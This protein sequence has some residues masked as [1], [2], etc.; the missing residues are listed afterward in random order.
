LA[1][2]VLVV[3]N[4]PDKPL[5]GIAGPLIDAGV[6][7]DVRS[8]DRDLPSVVGYAG[9]I[10]LPGLADPVD[11]DH[12]VR[13][14]RVAIDDALRSGLPILGLCLGGQLLV[15]ALGGSVYRCRPEL[16]F[17]DVFA[18]PAASSD[19][20]LR[21]APRRFSV[22]HAHAY[23]FEPPATA[24]ILLTNDVCVQACR[25]GETWAFQ[26]HPEVSGEWAMALASG[27]RGKDGGVP[28]NTI[29]FFARNGV[30]PERLERDALSA[31]QALRRVAHA[32]GSGFAAR[33]A[34]SPPRLV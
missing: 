13:R 19:P 4:D 1:G 16:G 14:A 20:L 24:E 29:D 34:R 11:D 2:S 9:L 12:A 32:I 21:G 7:L 5:G 33:L 31:D 3:Q 15:Q 25:Q 18:S 22:F 17:G 27:I 23:A 10:V 26:C 6:V 30:S 28:A 8:A